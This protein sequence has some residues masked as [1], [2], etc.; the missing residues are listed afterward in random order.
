MGGHGQWGQ[1]VERRAAPVAAPARAGGQPARI[2]RPVAGL[3]LA[4]LQAVAG[5][6]AAVGLLAGRRRVQRAVYLA[7]QDDL[8][9]KH[10]SGSA[11]EYAFVHKGQDRTA[12]YLEYDR[13]A[14][15]QRLVAA[16]SGKWTTVGTLG[17]SRGQEFVRERD[18]QQWF[19][20]L[21]ANAAAG[22]AEALGV[23]DALGPVLTEVNGAM[24]DVTNRIPA[25]V[26]NHIAFVAATRGALYNNVGGGSRLPKAA[27]LLVVRKDRPRDQLLE[28]LGVD[29]DVLADVTVQGLGPE[30]M[31]AVA[32]EMRGA[33]GTFR[34]V[35][36]LKLDPGSPQ[37]DMVYGSTVQAGRSRNARVVCAG[38]AYA[39]DLSDLLVTAAPG[40]VASFNTLPAV[41]A[42]SGW[43]PGTQLVTVNRGEGQV[44]AM[45]GWNALGAAAFANRQGVA[46]FDLQ[47]NWEWLHVQGAQIGG[48]TAGGNLVAGLYVTNSMMIPY[49]TMVARWAQA[50]PTH[51]QARFVAK[52]ATAGFAS[53]IAIWIEAKG[54]QVLGDFEPRQLISFGP[55]SGRIVDRLAN[56]MIKR[57]MDR[58][59]KVS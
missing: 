1:R 12:F 37:P 4:H 26:L 38:T 42:D 27:G 49:E 43:V 17:K 31:S 47:Q 8:I 3:D 20:G 21:A 2:R 24:T 57:G 51:F 48:A 41:T 55:L 11:T 16:L 32:G 36:E 22:K 52:P 18:R 19:D 14:R 44:K 35:L 10:S 33:P 40:V 7:N 30:L 15:V 13:I 53:E 29:A 34:N 28:W 25:P 54:H 39:D 46:H 9:Y 45:N 56:E 23:L 58:A 6:R 50:D 59:H 5:N